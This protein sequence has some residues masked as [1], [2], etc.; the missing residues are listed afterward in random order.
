MPQ[1]ILSSVENNFTQGLKTEYTGLN[2]PENAA[3]DTDNCIYTIVGDVKRRLGFDYEDNAIK[4]TISRDGKAL[5]QYKWDNASGDGETQIVVSQVGSILYFYK[6]SSATDT[7]PLSSTLLLSTAD[8]TV[9]AVDENDPSTEECQY[10]DGN[11]YLIVYNKNCNP[12]YC[13]MFGDVV[14]TSPISIKIR[15][16]NGVIDGLESSVRP[17]SLSNEHLYNLQN[18]GWTQGNKWFAHSDTFLKPGVG[19]NT[20]YIGPDIP[21]SLGDLVTAQTNNP[22]NPDF[23]PAQIAGNVVYYSGGYITINASSASVSDPGR[24]VGPWTIL[25]SSTGYINDFVSAVGVNPSNADVWWYFKDSTGAYNPSETNNGVSLASGAAPKGHFILEA[26]NQQRSTTST[27]TGMTP[28]I[29][30]LRP[31]TGAWFQGRVWYTGVNS[32]QVA[33]SNTSYY[34]WTENIYFSQV[35]VDNTQFGKCYQVN[36][37]TSEKLFDLLPTDGGVIS[38]QGCGAIYKLFPI[39]NGM[40]VFAANGIWFIT[41]SQGIGFTA[42]DYTI[43]KISSVK[44]ISS[45][46][47]VNVQGLPYFWN[48]EGIYTI[49]PSQ[50]GLGIQVDPITVST[51]LSFYDE[52]PIQ[53]KKYVRGDYDPI[54]YT[55]QWVYRDTVETG[56]TDRYQFNRILNYNVFNKSFFPYTVE[57]TDSYI[58]GVL[59]VSSPG[60]ILNSPIPKFKY[61]CS[62]KDGV[63]YDFSFAEEKDSS[64]L[65]WKSVDNIG[66]NYDSYFVTGYKLHGQGQRRFQLNYIYV[67]SNSE[68]PTSYRIQ[69]IWDYANDRSSGKWTAFQLVTNALTRFSRRFRR[70]KIR[71]RGLVLQFKISSVQGMPFDINGW[72]VREVQNTGV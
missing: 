53:S 59:F 17:D 62:A 23:Y 57:G 69:G 48:E 24:N 42:N 39:Q 65:D 50:Q 37:P 38:I 29:T 33:S 41:G 66:V 44:S 13:T 71:G 70:H 61:I 11:G 67:Y 32:S 22:G 9:F 60:N 7:N 27:T 19:N 47:F 43:T 4:T 6:S 12:F 58:H 55:I 8:L 54:E 21:V 16:F 31:T 40:L 46:S 35:I 26:F 20:F 68:V 18:Q 63:N 72:S 64:Y 5:S 2:F 30:R 28:V 51:I 25:P 45:T 36:D 52:I 56:I 49:T 15:D 10:A 34:S 1:Q 14:S 3:T